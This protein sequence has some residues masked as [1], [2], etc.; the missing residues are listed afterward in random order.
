VVGVIT[1]GR[2]SVQLMQR[3]SYRSTSAMRAAS[4]TTAT[5]AAAAADSGH[6]VV[7]HQQTVFIRPSC[8]HG[9]RSRRAILRRLHLSPALPAASYLAALLRILQPA[10]R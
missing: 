9:C 3:V 7:S 1:G 8:R 5:A 10:R 6:L 4:A 2:R